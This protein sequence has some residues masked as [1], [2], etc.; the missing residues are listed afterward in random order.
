MTR[1]WVYDGGI[2]V[3]P[4]HG[5]P[6]LVEAHHRA[7]VDRRDKSMCDSRSGECKPVT[8]FDKRDWHARTFIAA[9]VADVRGPA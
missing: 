3:R 9:T 7:Q 5:D 8:R 6:S 1:T 4:F 2:V